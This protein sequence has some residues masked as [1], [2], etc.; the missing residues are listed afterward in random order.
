M[1][2]HLIEV[3]VQCANNASSAIQRIHS[4]GMLI[5]QRLRLLIIQINRKSV[6]MIPS[7]REV[8]EPK[9]PEHV[10]HLLRK[11]DALPAAHGF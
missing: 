3:K 6:I 11:G 5:H 7:P 9:L 4:L 10:G 1:E 2:H 8:R